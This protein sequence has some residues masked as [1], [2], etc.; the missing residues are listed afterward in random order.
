MHPAP[1]QHLCFRGSAH[2]PSPTPFLPLPPPAPPP[3]INA[4]AP[5]SQAF[6]QLG[7]PWAVPIVSLGA[8]FAIFDTIIVVST[9]QGPPPS[10]PHPSKEGLPVLT[11]HYP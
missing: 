4:A 6:R 5:F 10:P 11:T 3:Q 9:A 1:L 8:F 2:P 7:M